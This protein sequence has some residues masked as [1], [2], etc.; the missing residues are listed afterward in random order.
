MLGFV[1]NNINII[2]CSTNFHSFRGILRRVLYVE[3]LNNLNVIITVRG[4][5]LNGK[6]SISIITKNV[7]GARKVNGNLSCA[8]PSHFLPSGSLS[9]NSQME[10]HVNLTTL[11][12][13]SLQLTS[14]LPS[15][16]EQG[17]M[18]NP[19][20]IINGNTVRPEVHRF[21]NDRLNENSD[22]E[23]MVVSQE[24]LTMIP[25]QTGSRLA[26]TCCCLLPYSCNHLP[27]TTLLPTGF[28]LS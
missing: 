7:F 15:A 12:L 5:I 19:E 1:I 16:R 14:S 3:S 23:N 20:Q 24:G 9:S 22:Q 18:D 8:T 17:P 26:I 25:D 11:Y 6:V 27:T 4:N 21:W 2:N 28:T 13:W 10:L